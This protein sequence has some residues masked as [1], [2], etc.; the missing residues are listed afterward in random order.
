MDVNQSHPEN[1]LHPF[2]LI[3]NV[4]P[5]TN[6]GTTG[7]GEISVNQDEHIALGEWVLLSLRTHLLCDSF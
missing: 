6:M 3:L 1:H 5:L 2:L 4:F 7:M